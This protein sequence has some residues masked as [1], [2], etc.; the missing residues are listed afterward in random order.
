GMMSA[1]SL[2]GGAAVEVTSLPLPGE[3]VDGVPGE[4][5]ERDRNDDDQGQQD[6]QPGLPL[7]HAQ[8]P[9]GTPDRGILSRGQSGGI[10]RLGDLRPRGFTRRKGDRPRRAAG[11][12]RRSASRTNLTAGQ[13]RHPRWTTG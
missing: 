7:Q 5:T 12:P 9:R 11:V 3:L 4:L 13:L 10:P 1:A 8:P 6:D 2:L